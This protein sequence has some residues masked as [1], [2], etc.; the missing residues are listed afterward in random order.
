MIRISCSAERAPTKDIQSTV[1]VLLLR[2]SL[3]S[4]LLRIT[5][6]GVMRAYCSGMCMVRLHYDDVPCP[7]IRLFL[8]KFHFFGSFFLL[9]VPVSQLKISDTFFSDGGQT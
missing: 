6:G 3:S 2:K 9:S 4:V 8:R 1:P 5:M 7:T